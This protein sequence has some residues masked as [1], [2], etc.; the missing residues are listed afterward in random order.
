MVSRPRYYRNN[1]HNRSHTRDVFGKW[2]EL[3]SHGTALDCLFLWR[4][5]LREPLGQSTASIAPYYSNDAAG[6]FAKRITYH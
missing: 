3:M 1:R 5:K 2:A 4:A 6:N